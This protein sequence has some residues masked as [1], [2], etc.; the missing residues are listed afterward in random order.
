MTACESSPPSRFHGV[1]PFSRTKA[2]LGM[3]A[4]ALREVQT[5]VVSHPTG[6]LFEKIGEDEVIYAFG[7]AADSTPSDDARLTSISFAHVTSTDM[8]TSTAS[9]AAAV[10]EM[11]TSLGNPRH[12]GNV[13]YARA[14]LVV[15]LWSSG[16]DEVLVTMLSDGTSNRVMHVLRQASDSM[17]FTREMDCP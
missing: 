5:S 7:P 4:S 6:G 3:K 12:C 8:M 13:D 15:A 2:T 10:Q 14:T 17:Q 9:W 16:N 11:R 1:V